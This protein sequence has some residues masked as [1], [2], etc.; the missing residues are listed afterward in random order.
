V[1]AE[2][3]RGIRRVHRIL[4]IR[5]DRLEDFLGPQPPRRARADALALEREAQQP[6]AARVGTVERQEDRV[7]A[8]DCRPPK[9]TRSL[10]RFPHRC[11]PLFS[12]AGYE[13]P[14]VEDVGFGPAL[15]IAL[16]C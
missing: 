12:T 11:L 2:G 15:R 3:L 9:I 6:L 16:T 14:A 4:R 10:G 8:A 5:H 13:V 7:R 1:E